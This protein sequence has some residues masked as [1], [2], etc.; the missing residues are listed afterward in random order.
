MA[1]A[2]RLRHSTQR[3]RR[4]QHWRLCRG[5][6]P[7]LRQSAHDRPG[8]DREPFHDGQHSVRPI[9]PHLLHLRPAR[10]ELYG[11]YRLL[12]VAGS[13]RRGT[14]RH[15]VRADRHGD[16]GRRQSADVADALHRLLTRL[17]AVAHGALPAIFRPGR[18]LCP[19][20][21]RRCHAAGQAG[22]SGRTRL[23]GARGR[24]CFGDQL[25]RQDRRYLASCG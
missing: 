20:R 1:R 16:R 23:P 11:G 6:E 21:G 19:G 8:R 14:V 22:N 7:R 13:L 10:P 17:H 18:R 15:L 3:R 5:I 4:F 25:R 12:V 9:Q 2:G 24:P